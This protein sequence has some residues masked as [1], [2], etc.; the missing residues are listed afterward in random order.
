MEVWA[1]RKGDEGILLSPD[2]GFWYPY[3][4][5]LELSL[6]LYMYWFA[7]WSLLKMSSQVLS[8][9]IETVSNVICSTGLDNSYHLLFHLGNVIYKHNFF[10]N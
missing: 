5:L 2:V 9:H 7:L 6:Q 10:S 3:T 1:I 4:L 8:I